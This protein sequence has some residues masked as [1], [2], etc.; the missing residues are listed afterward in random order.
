MRTILITLALIA[1]L[2]TQAGAAEIYD[3]DFN[4]K[5]RS[6]NFYLHDGASGGCFTNLKELREYAEEKLRIK[7]KF[8]TPEVGMDWTY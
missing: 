7:E 4:F 1:T 8:V 2:S 3:K 6:F 5:G